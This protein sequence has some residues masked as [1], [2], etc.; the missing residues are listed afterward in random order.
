MINDVPEIIVQFLTYHETI[1]NHSK[2]TVNGYYYDLRMFL[3]FMKRHKGLAGGKFDEIRVDDIDLQFIK[4]ITLD[5]IYAYLSF[6]SRERNLKQAARAREVAAIRSFFKFLTQKV[7]LLENNP[8]AELDSPKLK[9]TLPRYLKLDECVQLLSNVSGRF[10]ARDYCILTI[11]LNCGLRVSE[12]C[13]IDTTDI[14]DDSL[15]V[16]GKGSKERVVYLNDACLNAIKAYIPERERLQPLNEK[17]LF[18][19]QRRGRIDRRTVH[20]LVKKHLSE[21]GLDHT[22]YSSHKLRHSAATLML[23][24]G[25]DVR[26]LQEMLG[27]EHL[28]TTQIYTH[29][30]DTQLREA[31]KA[32]PLGKL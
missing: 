2:L 19:S 11:F 21:A 16:L 5:D 30:E 17:A 22:R 13:G 1:K 31:A 4:D 10:K 18:L 12:I 26:T 6:L 20:N 28:N 14:K 27:H 32:N 15:R 3:R 23:Q 8:V 7:H 9:K 24:N 29:I 25:V